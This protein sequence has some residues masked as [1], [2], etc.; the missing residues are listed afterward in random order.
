MVAFEFNIHSII[1][2]ITNSSSE[3]FVFEAKTGDILK[4]LISG[5]YPNYLT[6]YRDVELLS[7]LSN[8]DLECYIDWTYR[9]YGESKDLHIFPGIIQEDTYEI[10]YIHGDRISFSLK[11]GFIEKYREK[12]LQ[13]IDPENKTW[14]LYSIDENP[15]WDCQEKLM[16]IG[17][18]YHLG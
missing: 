12:L 17:T 6:E 8:E 16:Q 18:R 3:L 14:L 13:I 9:T 5:V 4:D 1:D 2:I 11:E 15:N 10:S 7:D